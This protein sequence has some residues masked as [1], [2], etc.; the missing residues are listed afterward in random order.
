MRMFPAI[1]FTA[2]KGDTE[3]C[4]ISIILLKGIK[5]ILGSIL[6]R[7]RLNNRLDCTGIGKSVIEITTKMCR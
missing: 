5:F 7:L 6:P 3:F 2:T 1:C 4:I